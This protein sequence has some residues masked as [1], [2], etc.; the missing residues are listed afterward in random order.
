MG[1]PLHELE[2]LIKNHYEDIRRRIAAQVRDKTTVD[3]LVQ[4]TFARYVQRHQGGLRADDALGFL[5]GTASVVVKEHFRKEGKRKRFIERLAQDATPH[6]VPMHELSN[7]KPTLKDLIRELPAPDQEL[8]LARH[9][10]GL[11]WQ[12]ISERVQEPLQ[13]LYS[14]YTRALEHLCELWRNRGESDD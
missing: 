8:M 13:T 6:A 1:S 12:R 4:E 11:T 5:K 2:Q 9:R 3:D 7:P 14:R 10:D